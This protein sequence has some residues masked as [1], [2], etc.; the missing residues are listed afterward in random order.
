[1]TNK[2]IKAI[3]LQADSL[4]EENANCRLLM[5]LFLHAQIISAE[6]LGLHIAISQTG[7]PVLDSGVCAFGIISIKAND[8]K[9]WAGD[10]RPHNPIAN[11]SNCLL[12]LETLSICI[13]TT[14]KIVELYYTNTS[15]LYISLVLD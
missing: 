4:G 10:R 11:N 2:G 12:H 3:K 13:L 1:M 6:M 9:D 14:V 5:R 15:F 7:N 8:A